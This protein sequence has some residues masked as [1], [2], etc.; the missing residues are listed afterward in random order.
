[1]SI[2]PT[3][4]YD[5]PGAAIAFLTGVL[6]F[7]SEHVS[8]A[9][10]GSVEHA[11][12]SFR[13]GPHDPPGVLML[14]PRRPGDP[15]DTGRAVTYLVVDD[16]DERH[17]RAVAAGARILHGPVDQPYGSREVAVADPEGNAWTLGT[18]R[19]QAKP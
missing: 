11:E 1:M 16:P 8:T 19:P 7:T 6:G 14:G 5:D 3:L 12:L 18:Y 10:D 15:F 13:G 17:A 2:V 9:A 4:R